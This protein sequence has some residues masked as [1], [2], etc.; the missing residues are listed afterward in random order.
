MDINWSL[1]L[2]PLPSDRFPQNT[3]EKIEA[4]E[5]SH[6]IWFNDA[7][8]S[9]LLF[10]NGS[11]A[12][13]RCIYSGEEL[14]TYFTG[15]LTL[16]QIHHTIIHMKKVEEEFH[17]YF[18]DILLP[19]GDGGGSALICVGKS[20]VYT[21]KVYCINYQ[22]YDYNSYDSMIRFIADDIPMFLSL[23]ESDR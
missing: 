10:S 8:K 21:D 15:F 12:I 14:Y 16:E 5:N 6:Q 3:P 4:F 18:S 9:L 1:Y 17:Y 22:D 23:L 2:E 19:V 13:N 11:T 20:G 7:L